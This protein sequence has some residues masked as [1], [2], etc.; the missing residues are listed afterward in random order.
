MNKN[1]AD[2]VI[3]TGGVRFIGSALVKRLAR[4]YA[5]EVLDATRSPLTRP[6]RCS[7]AAK[8]RLSA[9]GSE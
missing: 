9:W 6:W 4:R 3:V 2:V 5:V 7:H 1:A 8:S